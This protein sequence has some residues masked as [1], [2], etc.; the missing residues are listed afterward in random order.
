[1]TEGG[2]QVRSYCGNFDSPTVKYD[3][4]FMY[5]C[6]ADNY[7][8]EAHDFGKGFF[9]GLFLNEKRNISPYYAGIRHGMDELCN[10]SRII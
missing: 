7:Y 9:F 8:R 2:K 1:M 5:K 6:S 3:L 10:V 4:R